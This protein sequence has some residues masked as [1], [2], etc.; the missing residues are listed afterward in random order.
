VLDVGRGGSGD[1]WGLSAARLDR[2]RLVAG[3]DADLLVG[4]FRSAGKG[5]VAARQLQLILGGRAVAWR[6]VALA[7][8]AEAEVALRFSVP[9]GTHVG[10]LRLAG[11]DPWDLNDHLPV[12]MGAHPAARVAVVCERERTAEAGRALRL[13]LSAGPG[14]E[15]KAFLAETLTPASAGLSNLSAYGAFV[16]VGPPR[17]SEQIR[18]RLARRIAAGAGAVLLCEDPAALGELA[19]KLG[20]PVPPCEARLVRVESRARLVP[21]SAG[22]VLFAT[23]RPAAAADVLKR[24]V[25]F[26]PGRG[27]ALARARAPGLDLPALVEHGLGRGPVLAFCS[28]PARRYSLLTERAHANLFVPLL[29][30]LVGRAAGLTDAGRVARPGGSL[31]VTAAFR[32]R[33][34]RFWRYDSAG[35][36]TPLGSPDRN[37]H[38]HIAAPE[39]PGA[40]R[41]ISESDG[42]LLAERALAV[43][44]AP[45]ELSGARPPG[46]EAPSA[47]GDLPAALAAAVRPARRGRDLSGVPAALGLALLV[48]EAL[49]AF[50]V[51]RRVPVHEDAPARQKRGRAA[52]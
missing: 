42:R 22:E 27:R 13:A 34:A 47:V 33:S 8:G 44:L 52:A 25:E 39:V 5:G 36:R 41:V 11:D 30:E 14:A 26:R 32:E 6:S 18:A 2:R 23:F 3:E 49:V 37:L 24:V 51:A 1:D 19:V 45:E 35:L 46:A 7:P 28:S 50:L 40:Y 38:L 16:L 20:M 4:V 21:E 9:A 29:H 43:R 48:C 10:E 31:R 15:R 12:A 17:L